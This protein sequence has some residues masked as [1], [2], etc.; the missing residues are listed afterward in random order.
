[1]LS[2]YFFFATSDVANCWQL[3]RMQVKGTSLSAT[4]F[5][6]LK[7]GLQNQQLSEGKKHF[8]NCSLHIV[9]TMI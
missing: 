8:K 3:E 9:K 2:D 5:Q 7:H 6:T 4:L 1:M